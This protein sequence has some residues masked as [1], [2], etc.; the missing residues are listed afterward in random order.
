MVCVKGMQNKQP[1][2]VLME[3]SAEVKGK[4][5]SSVLLDAPSMSTSVE[6]EAVTSVLEVTVPALLVLCRLWKL[7]AGRSKC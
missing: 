5:P 3:V 1:D 7:V 6:A 4:L 2:A